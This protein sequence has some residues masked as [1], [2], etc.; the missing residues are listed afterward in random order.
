MAGAVR[1]GR[2]CPFRE[3]RAAKGSRFRK[4]SRTP[5]PQEGAPT[6][7][8]PRSPS[9]W[10]LP[11]P[12]AAP[13]KDQTDQSGNDQQRQA[14]RRCPCGRVWYGNSRVR[15]IDPERARR[16]RF[17]SIR[18]Y[19]SVR[20]SPVNPR[21]G[22]HRDRRRE[23]DSV[24]A[25]AIRSPTRAMTAPGTRLH[26]QIPDVHQPRGFT[27]EHVT[28]AKG[29][30]ARPPVGL[31]LEQPT[32]PNLDDVAYD[33]PL[34]VASAFRNE[35]TGPSHSATAGVA[36]VAR[37]ITAN[38]ETTDRRVTRRAKACIRCPLQPPY[39]DCLGS[40]GLSGDGHKDPGVATLCEDATRHTTTCRRV[41]WWQ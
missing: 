41:G 38:A 40:L 30:P 17:L 5:R 22:V 33:D 20:D 39:T 2:R 28:D 24:N 23:V 4:P 9:V 10:S 18:S 7:E 19:S 27:T 25:I 8:R 21:D 14:G 26:H 6:G 31:W 35:G 11:R 3:S 34:A 1:R 37:T 36:P 29:E 12:D 16:R 13:P 15:S 32:G